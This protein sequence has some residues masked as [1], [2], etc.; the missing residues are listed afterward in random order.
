MLES[1]LLLHLTYKVISMTRTRLTNLSRRDFGRISMVALGGALAGPS[2][3]ANSDRPRVTE[4]FGEVAPGF[5]RVKAAFA[6]NFEQH[7]RL[8]LPAVCITAA[9]R[10]LTSGVEWPTR[11]AVGCGRKIPSCW[12]SRARKGRPRSVHTYWPSAA[13]SISMRQW[14]ST[15]R[16]SPLRA[17][18]VFRCVGC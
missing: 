14:P 13:S 3:A 7:G 4:I 17:S 11:G 8:A 6:A 10:W 15:G 16:S 5:E 9:R 1:R 12:C 2:L 18:K